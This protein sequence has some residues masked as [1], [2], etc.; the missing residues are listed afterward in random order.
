MCLEAG[1][2]KKSLI[3][4]TQPRRIAA[5]SVEA[6]ISEELKSDKAVGSKIRF[7][8]NTLPENLIRIMTDGMLLSEFHS[9][10]L[11]SRYDT[12]IIDEAHER[13]LNIDVVLGLLKR[14]IIKR[15]DLKVII[16]SATLDTEKFAKHFFN[17]PVIEVEGKTFPVEIRYEEQLKE[18]S[19]LSLPEFCALKIEEL[20]LSTRSGDILVFLPTEADIKETI[21]IVGGKFLDR[22]D[23]LPLYA[24]LPSSEQKK[25]FASG[26]K[27]KLIVST[28][29]AE[30]SLTI[31]GIKYVIDSGLARISRYS[32]SSGTHALPVDPVSRASADQRAGR[33]GR[34]ETVCVYVFIQKKTTI[35]E[36]LLRLRRY[37]GQILPKLFSVF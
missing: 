26:G 37:S 36:L 5:L 1:R 10:P 28:N 21:K 29:V 32:P 31:V 27:R 33:C 24:R 8:N 9:D 15:K 20:V 35:P 6:R 4:C 13:S 3:G 19:G 25:V 7:H 17:A 2:G 16:T 23:I 30:T 34:V 22:L 18:Y 14:L 11:L 12:I